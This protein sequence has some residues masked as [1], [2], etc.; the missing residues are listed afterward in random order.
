MLIPIAPELEGKVIQI[1]LDDKFLMALNERRELWQM[2]GALG[3]SP[4]ER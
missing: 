1:A 2:S 4:E 3:S